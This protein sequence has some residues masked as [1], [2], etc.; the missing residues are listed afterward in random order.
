MPKPFPDFS[1]PEFRHVGPRGRMEMLREYVMTREEDVPPEEVRRLFAEICEV[2]V[3]LFRDARIVS[4]YAM[5]ADESMRL[6][7][8][9]IA[10]VRP[11]ETA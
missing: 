1:R 5:D 8:Q 6:L 11:E 7:N 3:E 4:R 10:L 2:S 9:Q